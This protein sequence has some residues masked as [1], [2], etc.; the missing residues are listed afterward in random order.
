MSGTT[1]TLAMIGDNDMTRNVDAWQ[2]LLLT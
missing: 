1:T 2:R